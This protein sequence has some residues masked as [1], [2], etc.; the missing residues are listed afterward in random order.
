MR[1][2][3]V[4]L[5][6]Y[7]S[8]CRDRLCIFTSDVKRMASEADQQAFNRSA[9][10]LKTDSL[11]EGKSNALIHYYVL[12]RRRNRVM[13]CYSTNYD[14][15]ME[16]KCLIE[17]WNACVTLSSIFIWHYPSN[18]IV[19]LHSTDLSVCTKRKVIVVH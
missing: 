3:T 12:K 7:D 9:R 1:Q 11:P 4:Q 16:A 6:H 14:I 5:L 2:L 13:I 15:N 8:D 10:K 18:L 17:W 19:L